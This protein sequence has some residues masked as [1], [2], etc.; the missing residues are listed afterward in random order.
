MFY[1]VF[2][3]KKKGIYYTWDECKQQV[4]GYKGAKFKKFKVLEEAVYYLNH[5]FTKETNKPVKTQ[6]VMTFFGTPGPTPI[7]ISELNTSI[8][9]K[10]TKK[11]HIYTDGS[12]INN[13]RPNAQAGYGV[14]FGKDD[15]RNISEPLD[16]GKPTNNRA[17]LKAIIEAVKKSIDI[18][19]KKCI[20]LVIHTDSEY[21]M[22]CF[23]EY[24]RKCAVNHWKDKK[25]DMIVNHDLIK[26]GLP[27]FRKYSL[28]ELYH[29]KA[30][31]NRS[32]VHSIG[33]RIADQLAVQG[34]KKYGEKKNSI[35]T[36]L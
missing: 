21:S 11:M 13:G 17:E 28:L 20:Q 10:K 19:E 1:S 25:G 6:N 9:F 26:E 5:G 32:D 12:C 31:T 2:L 23:G 30:H 16:S 36:F 22:R 24:G 34:A 29:V 18:L 33:N 3:G 35:T 27:Y 8:P 4:T 15:E 7:D 14:Y